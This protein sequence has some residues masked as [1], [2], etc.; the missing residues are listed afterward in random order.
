MQPEVTIVVCRASIH[1]GQVVVVADHPR[2]VLPAYST[3]GGRGEVLD[4][5]G[6]V[7]RGVD[8]TVLVPQRLEEVV[9]NVRPTV[10]HR[11]RRVAGVVAHHVIAVAGRGVLLV[12]VGKRCSVRIARGQ[13]IGV[14]REVCVYD[15]GSAQLVVLVLEEEGGVV[16]ARHLHHL[17]SVRL[18]V[19][20]V[21]G[22]EVGP[23]E[24]VQAVDARV[25]RPLVPGSLGDEPA[26][27][28]D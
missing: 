6:A 17:G 21:V 20:G 8:G 18:A 7:D 4:L 26:Q 3:G 5:D 13:L 2:S 11:R 10:H 24:D 25:T 19:R 1:S 14:A 22:K 27:V 16:P 23:A 9:H 12:P 28:L 15:E